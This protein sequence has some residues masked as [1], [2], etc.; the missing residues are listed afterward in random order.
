[1]ITGG[2]NFRAFRFY[3]GVYPILLL[4]LFYFIS[5]VLPR[6]IQTGFNSPTL[7][8]RPLIFRSSLVV[9]LLAGFVLYQVNDWIAAQEISNISRAYVIAKQG[10]EQGRFI[11]DL[12]SSLPELP[13]VGVIRAGGIKYTYPGPVVDLM[14]L[15][16]LLMAHNGGRRVG[17]KSHAAFEKQT[18][19]QLQPDLMSAE[20]VSNTSWQYRET[21][22]KQS[23]DN[24]VALKGLY[25]DAAFL[26]RYVYAKIHQSGSGMGEALVGWFRREFLEELQS[27]GSFVIE[28]YEYDRQNE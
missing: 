16:N 24:S 11:Y 18:F 19:Y 2:D 1:L 26:D 8:G 17:L 15:N 5:W 6:Y 13:S 4:C 23:W 22:L 9:F 25:N 7:T 27:R 28:R 10:R 14:G 12:F 20:V 21:D 3:Q